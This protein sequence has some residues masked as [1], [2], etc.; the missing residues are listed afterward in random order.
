MGTDKKEILDEIMAFIES[1]DKII[2]SIDSFIFETKH[3]M[4]SG[5]GTQG[6]WER[7][8]TVE[9]EYKGYLLDISIAVGKYGLN[10]IEESEFKPEHIDEIRGGE[11]VTKNFIDIPETR[12]IFESVKHSI[13]DIKEKLRKTAKKIPETKTE[14]NKKL[15]FVDKNGDGFL[16]LNG[17]ETFICKSI[18]KPFL[19]LKILLDNFGKDLK[20]KD[21]V[22]QMNFVWRTRISDPYEREDR[23]RNSSVK[24]LQKKCKM[25]DNNLVIQVK[26][27]V[28]RI[29]NKS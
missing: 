14:I 22:E 11:S 6:L 24:D 13:I 20:V 27:G 3:P 25:S 8:L 16:R 12:V 26:N 15:Y 28:I 1:G 21:V 5:Q 4:Y 9:K 17:K 18:N 7:A 23:L 19:L 29:C 2:K 10:K